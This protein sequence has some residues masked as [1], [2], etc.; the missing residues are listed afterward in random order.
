V[1]TIWLCRPTLPRHSMWLSHLMFVRLE[2]VAA[3]FGVMIWLL[4]MMWCRLIS[5][6]CDLSI[7]I[8]LGD[9]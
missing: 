1:R 3:D 4:E 8:H 6:I 7:L 5:A 9:H 2:F